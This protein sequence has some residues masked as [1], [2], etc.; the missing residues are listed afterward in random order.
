MKLQARVQA[1]KVPR[2][3]RHREIEELPVLVL[4]KPVA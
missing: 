1:E 4:E 2:S 3:G